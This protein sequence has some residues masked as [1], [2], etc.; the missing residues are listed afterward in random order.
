M[1]HHWR[2]LLPVT[3]PMVVVLLSTTALSG[4]SNANDDHSAATAPSPSETSSKTSKPDITQ[5]SDALVVGR[6]AFPA[7]TDQWLPPRILSLDSGR[8]YADPKECAALVGGPDGIP[9]GPNSVAQASLRKNGGR[10]F[11]FKATVTLPANGN[12]PDWSSILDKCHTVSDN[13]A[14]WAVQPSQAEQSPPWAINATVTN[15]DPHSQ[16]YEWKAFQIAG[17]YRGLAV[18]VSVH[19]LPEPTPEDVAAA[20]NVFNSQITKLEAAP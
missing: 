16:Y 12:L 18:V 13:Q 11:D 7:G 9:H 4:C 10:D 15:D 20:V 19:R 5:I 1:I 6:D 17:T 8:I 14:H 3:A 2:Q